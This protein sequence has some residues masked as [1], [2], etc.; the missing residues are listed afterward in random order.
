MNELKELGL[1]G[2]ETRVYL[3]LLRLGSA[4][5]GRI[6]E[7]SG[8]HRRN[9]YDA[10]ERLVK[11]GLAGH[12]I[13]GKIRYFE[14]ASPK[15]LLSIIEE[16]R[17]ALEGKMKRINSI[18]PG[19][20]SIHGSRERENVIIYKGLKGVKTVL[21]DILKTG[22]PNHVLGA[23]KPPKQIK[24]YLNNFHR[25]R[26]RL[27]ISDKLIFNRNDTERANML[28]KMPLT[29]VRFLQSSNE[30]KTAINMYGD[31]VAILMWS[32]P[33]GILIENKEV[34]KS[35]RDYFSLLWKITEKP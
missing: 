24:N 9:V 17:E 34:A 35:F 32:E 29:E 16:E 13:K 11:R 5:A 15:C 18:L 7:E 1:T 30:S 6:T 26:V 8:V 10:I 12:V 2:N 4:T 31:K 21:E 20:L 23:H 28:A 25:K 3:T 27:G 22:K 33:I 19:L 14:A